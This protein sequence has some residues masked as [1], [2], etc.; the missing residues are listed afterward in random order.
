[1]AVRKRSATATI[2]HHLDLATYSALRWEQ[3]DDGGQRESHGPDLRFLILLQLCSLPF[4][5]HLK[6][7]ALPVTSI[8]RVFFLFSATITDYMRYF[9]RISLCRFP[10]QSLRNS[11]QIQ[12]HEKVYLHLF[13]HAAFLVMTVVFHVYRSHVVIIV[14]MFLMLVSKSFS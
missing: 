9:L 3:Q 14:E 10:L 7:F 8:S 1:M 4:I 5:Q 12:C 2:W 11:S 13:S 6:V